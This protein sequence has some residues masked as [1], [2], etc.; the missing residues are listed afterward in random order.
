MAMGLQL[1]EGTG[2]L[3]LSFSKGTTCTATRLETDVGI[4]KEAKPRDEAGRYIPKGPRG[5]FLYA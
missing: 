5:K 3:T 2:F 4:D 1:L